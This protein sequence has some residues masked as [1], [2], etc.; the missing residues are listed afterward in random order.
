MSG[1]RVAS[2][3]TQSRSCNLHEHFNGRWECTHLFAF[4]LFSLSTS[5]LL[6][7]PLLPSAPLPAP[8]NASI[9][10]ST[11]FTAPATVFPIPLSN[12]SLQPRVYSAA[13]FFI[14]SAH[15]QGRPQQRQTQTRVETQCTKWW[16]HLF[17]Y[18]TLAALNVYFC[19]LKGSLSFS[20][21]SCTITGRLSSTLFICT[22]KA[23]ICCLE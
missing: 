17:K 21:L 15:K 16:H 14:F 6:F 10:E 8:L 3:N 9:Q 11:S 22:Q 1:L 4:V 18:Q 2:K 23:F 5:A 13:L 12:A 7:P 20:L 19:R